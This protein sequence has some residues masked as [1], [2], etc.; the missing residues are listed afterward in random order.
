MPA[1]RGPYT[2][3]NDYADVGEP[4]KTLGTAS[5]VIK[6][7]DDANAVLVK[8][9]GSVDD[10][11]SFDVEFMTETELAAGEIAPAFIDAYFTD[12][13]LQAKSKL[14][15]TPGVVEAKIAGPRV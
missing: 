15:D 4:V 6:N 1:E 8:V 5:M 2:T 3:T 14:A 11:D 12:I 13:K 7:S 10:G 9:L